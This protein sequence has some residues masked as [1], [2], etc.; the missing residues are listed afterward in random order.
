MSNEVCVCVCVC[1]CSMN[2]QFLNPT[3][4]FIQGKHV[5]AKINNNDFNR[6]RSY[7]D[8]IFVACDGETYSP[9]ILDNFLF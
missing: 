3:A 5:L 6:K 9:E 8:V 1:V 7:F 2:N 4:L